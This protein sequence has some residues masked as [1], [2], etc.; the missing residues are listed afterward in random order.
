[1]KLSEHLTIEEIV[2]KCGQCQLS[3]LD[4]A[5][6]FISQKIVFVFEEIRTMVN[7]PLIITSGLRCPEYN[8]KIGGSNNSAH[9]QGLALDIRVSDS[10]EREELVDVAFMKGIR[11]R[12]V[13]RDFVHIDVGESPRFPQEVLWVY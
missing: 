7:R 1:M 3:N 8:Q 9:L 2:C 12:G 6:N 4:Y 11:R 10:H 13:A 5:K